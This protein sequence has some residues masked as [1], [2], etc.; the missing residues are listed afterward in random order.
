M[1]TK[2]D[3]QPGAHNGNVIKH[4]DSLRNVL[5][6][7]KHTSGQDLYQ[8]LVDIM[9]HIVTHCPD[10]GI[11][12]F[13][14]ISYLLKQQRDGKIESLGEFLR[15]TDERQ[16]SRPGSEVQG[17]EESSKY[18]ANAKKLL[19][20]SILIM[21]VKK[22]KFNSFHRYLNC[23]NCYRRR[24]EL[25]RLLKEEKVEKMPPLTEALRLVLVDMSQI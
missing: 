24:E 2:T 25:Q 9:N 10:N 8:H 17:A 6:N 21:P 22:I 15:I 5:K 3:V 16:Y 18:I 19:D 14:E 7:A 20:V 13:E 12:K 1:A 4:F 23:H 11:D